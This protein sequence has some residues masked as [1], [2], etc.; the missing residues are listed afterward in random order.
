MNNQFL[1]VSGLRDGS[2]LI[3]GWLHNYVSVQ[4]SMLNE[5]FSSNLDVYNVNPAENRYLINGDFLIN[6]L[7]SAGSYLHYQT[8]YAGS[9]I[10]YHVTNNTLDLFNYFQII[11]NPEQIVWVC[12]FVYSHTCFVFARINDKFKILA[13]KVAFPSTGT[14]ELW[15]DENIFTQSTFFELI[16]IES[17]LEYN[18]VSRYRRFQKIVA[19]EFLKN[20]K[21]GIMMYRHKS[22]VMNGLFCKIA[23]ETILKPRF[24]S[25]Q[26]TKTWK[27]SIL[28]NFITNDT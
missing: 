3:S 24:S 12:Q 7:L 10:D 17:D 23:D 19:K 15:V 14:V 1:M 5:L 28:S 4:G 11:N 20:N 27:E 9:N 16:E 26:E 13:S 21:N 25:I 8:V 2:P 6:P 18:L 22:K